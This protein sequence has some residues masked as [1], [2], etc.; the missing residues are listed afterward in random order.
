MTS[1]AA[2][3]WWQ[4]VVQRAKTI[5]ALALAEQSRTELQEQSLS[6]FQKDNLSVQHRSSCSAKY[7]NVKSL[8]QYERKYQISNGPFSSVFCV[9]QRGK[10]YHTHYAAKY[11][12]ANTERAKR[13]VSRRGRQSGCYNITARLMSSSNYST[14]PRSSG[15]LRFFTVSFTPSSSL[16]SYQVKKIL[17][18]FF[19]KLHNWENVCK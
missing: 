5:T 4:W 3:S 18:C 7:L 8:L 14:V 9:K 12:R 1:S 15:L 16:S 6:I 13:E 17:G 11:L 19:I 10:R 2:Q